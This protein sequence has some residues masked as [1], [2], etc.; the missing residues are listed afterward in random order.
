[1]SLIF[2]FVCGSTASAQVMSVSDLRDVS[3]TAEYY[4]DLKSLV[5]YGIVGNDL[6]VAREDTLPPSKE[7]IG[8]MFYPET[9]VTNRQL[10]FLFDGSLSYLKDVIDNFKLPDGLDPA[11]KYAMMQDLR[12][13]INR[14]PLSKLIL[15]T[16]KDVVGLKMTFEEAF[17]LASLVDRHKLGADVL[18]ADGVYDRFR[19]LSEKEISNILGNA[20]LVKP[21]CVKTRCS[22]GNL[23]LNYRNATVTRGRL[24]RILNKYLEVHIEKLNTIINR[25]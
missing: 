22:I 1:M 19:R 23:Q 13:S 18:N 20:L 5:D 25:K 6:I 9:K 2:I 17:A 10:V 7:P 4:A 16:T 24:V 15:Y 12:K 14:K 11:A 3:P 21:T 8:S